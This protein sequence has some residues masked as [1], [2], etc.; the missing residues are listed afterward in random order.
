MPRG[1]LD[2]FWKWL[3]GPPRVW[4]NYIGYTGN[5]LHDTMW[6]EC[7]LPLPHGHKV[8]TFDREGFTPAPDDDTSIHRWPQ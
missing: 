6:P 8:G 7:R 1:L 2:R 3:D 5:P 4:M